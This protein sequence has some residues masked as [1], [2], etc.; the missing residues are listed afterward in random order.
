MAIKNYRELRAAVADWM[1]RPGLATPIPSVVEGINVDRMAVFCSH[2][3]AEFNRRVRTEDMVTIIFNSGCEKQSVVLLPDNILGVRM[4]MITEQDAEYVTPEQFTKAAE[5]YCDKPIYTRVANQIHV[6]PEMAIADDITIVAYVT[7]PPLEGD[8]DSNW[9]LRK[10]PD[11]YLY[12]CLYE[13]CAYVFDPEH[14]AIWREKFESAIAE[15]IAHD[16]EDRWSGSTMRI[17]SV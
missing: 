15:L 12:G 9:V 13:A 2:I 8:D 11:V 17:R 10:F 4:V 14:E 7:V 6:Y 1:D 3:E 16:Q 5:I